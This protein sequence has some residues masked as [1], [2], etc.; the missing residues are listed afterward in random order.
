MSH[1]LRG[2][3][4][5]QPP[6]MRHFASGI[7]FLSALV[8]SA[9]SA[10]ASVAPGPLFPQTEFPAGES[11]FA[12]T[13]GDFDGDGHVDLAVANMLSDDVVI[14]R[15]IEGGGFVPGV[16]LGPV[17]NSFS[18]LSADLNRDGHLDLLAADVSARVVAF[19]GAGDGTFP[20]EVSLLPGASAPVGLALRDFDA[21]G[22]PD[23]AVAD[24]VNR[25]VS[26][27]R[28]AGDGTFALHQTIPLGLSPHS[29]AVADFD[30]DGSLDIIIGGDIRRPELVFL[31]GVQDGTFQIGT[32]LVLPRMP[33]DL[34]VVDFGGDGRADLVVSSGGVTVNQPGG[35][36]L[37]SIL[38]D[39]SF[40]LRHEITSVPSASGLAVADF[41]GD[42]FDDLAVVSR[43]THE[44]AVFLARG[45]SGFI[46]LPRNGVGTFPRRI[47]AAHL[48]QDAQVD[49]AVANGFT[50]DLSILHGLPGGGFIGR[51]S[52]HLE[53][54]PSAVV[55]V[56]LD[57]DGWRDLVA[58]SVFTPHL[59]TLMGT[60]TD[61]FNVQVRNDMPARLGL[62]APGDFNAD[63]R[64]DVA[65]LAS[66]S[67][68]P[69]VLI[70]LGDGSG[71]LQ[72]APLLTGIAGFNSQLN[73]IGS[74]QL[75]GDGLDD[76]VLSDRS[77]DEVVVLFGDGR[78]GYRSLRRLPTPD[79]PRAVTVADF[80]R[81]G[82]DDFV[83]V[84]GED[85]VQVFTSL[86]NTLFSTRQVVGASSPIAVVA[87]DLDSD[88][89]PDLVVLSGAP[90]EVTVFR[91]GGLGQ[92]QLA[93]RQAVQAGTRSLGAG[94]FNLDGFM[95]I[96]V[97]NSVGNP[98]ASGGGLIHVLLGGGDGTLTSGGVFGTGPNPSTVVPG[99]FNGDGRIDIATRT[100][101]AVTLLLNQAPYPERNPLQ[102]QPPDVN[103]FLAATALVT[104]PD[105]ASQ[106][107][108][109]PHLIL[110]AEVSRAT[111]VISL[112]AQVLAGGDGKVGTVDDV[113]LRDTLQARTSGVDLALRY[114]SRDTVAIDLPP[115]FSDL[116]LHLSVSGVERG[117]G[118]I[119][120]DVDVF[121]IQR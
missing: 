25:D 64:P 71:G 8:W 53:P 15:G 116:D 86:G 9:V 40:Q 107:V 61:R 52:T 20:T 75:D 115:D 80:D 93:T 58:G 35:V 100:D 66:S 106:A 90:P 32:R 14:M 73:S 89:R 39:E 27:L 41:D 4:S 83:V 94:D 33:V 55:S 92:F 70:L 44:V 46:A 51:R 36:A 30:G 85:G 3:S 109:S 57:S 112:G 78:A 67:G 42:S 50:N 114:L 10:T 37:F 17:Q 56:D 5:A 12:M 103:D 110:P 19:F 38:G 95:D 87:P 84:G 104:F 49:L 69:V 101:F 81:N 18:I 68:R 59:F 113:D 34:A 74:G 54:N 16:R 1:R 98:S 28:G 47:I 79:S 97:G 60:G 99:D 29:L 31:P 91:N 6:G 63:G 2:Y 119:R 7:C 23:L 21:D 24:A 121:H 117:V 118:R 88:G 102:G 13:A 96:A 120:R 72:P 22:L 45:D 108:D 65:A 76:L 26:I 82:V 11:P 48:D 77:A 105:G 62:L 111:L 43:L